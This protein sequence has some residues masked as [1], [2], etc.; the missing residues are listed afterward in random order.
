MK[1]AKGGILV[2]GVSFC[3]PAIVFIISGDGKDID[4]ENFNNDAE[5]KNDN[6]FVPKVTIILEDENTDLEELFI[7]KTNRYPCP[8]TNNYLPLKSN[9]TLMPELITQK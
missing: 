5:M 9:T 7:Q 3:I 6:I 8:L 1:G 2:F 4:A